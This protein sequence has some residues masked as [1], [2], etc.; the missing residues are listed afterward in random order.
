MLFLQNGMLKMHKLLEKRKSPLLL[1]LLGLLGPHPVGPAVPMMRKK[2][3][4]RMFPSSTLSTM[5]MTRRRIRLLH[6]IPF[7]VLVAKGGVKEIFLVSPPSILK[8][9]VS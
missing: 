3:L 1:H 4:R 2:T 5:M 8:F 7:L 6:F 9:L